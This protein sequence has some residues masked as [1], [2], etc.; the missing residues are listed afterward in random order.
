[1][2][3]LLRMATSRGR[4]WAGSATVAT[5][6]AGDTKRGNRAIASCGCCSWPADEVARAS[7]GYVG[8]DAQGAR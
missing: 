3:W 4:T 1:V 7:D 5:S 2:C 8:W 6:S